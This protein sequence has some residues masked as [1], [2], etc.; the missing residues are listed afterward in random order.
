MKYKTIIEPFRIKTVEPIRQTTEAERA[1]AADGP[2]AGHSLGERA[3]FLRGVDLGQPA[4]D[5][6]VA[7][8]GGIVSTWPNPDWSTAIAAIMAGLGIVLGVVIGITSIV[9]MA[10]MIRG[11]DQSLRDMIGANTLE[12]VHIF[13]I[14]SSCI[15]YSS[16]TIF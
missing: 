11:F 7:A 10:A 3:H 4:L 5:R 8:V 2:R 9:G 16:N 15:T 6:T 1:V 12:G 14:I 13:F